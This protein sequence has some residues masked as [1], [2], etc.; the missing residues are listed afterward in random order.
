MWDTLCRT[1]KEIANL[2]DLGYDK[3]NG[4]IVWASDAEND[5]SDG[6]RIEVGV[7]G[8]TVRIQVGEKA[9]FYEVWY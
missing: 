9:Y 3:N 7:G 2:A 8:K 1:G 4:K 5:V 6:D